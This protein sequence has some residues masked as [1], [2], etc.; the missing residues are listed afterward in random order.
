MHP[1][2]EDNGFWLNFCN[3]NQA[4]HNALLTSTT[5]HKAF[6]IPKVLSARHGFSSV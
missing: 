6:D 4:W 3:T 2:A 5:I 1:D